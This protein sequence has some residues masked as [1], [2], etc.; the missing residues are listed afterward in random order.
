MNLRDWQEIALKGEARSKMRRTMPG[1][2]AMVLDKILYSMSEDG[3][4]NHLAGKRL[5]FG[6]RQYV[7]GLPDWPK[8][9]GREEKQDGSLKSDYV[10]ARK[11]MGGLRDYLEALALQEIV[12]KGSAEELVE[13][14]RAV[15]NDLYRLVEKH[16]DFFQSPLGAF[17]LDSIAP[18]LERV[19]AER[20][21][22]TTDE[23]AR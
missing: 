3:D 5:S 2:Y 8:V 22:T 20:T 15:L 17:K 18:A 11:A 14:E 10:S 7:H 1:A 13:R 21:Q 23:G 4:K 6:D 9:P 19:I 16:N 12:G